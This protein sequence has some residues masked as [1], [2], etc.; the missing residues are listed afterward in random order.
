MSWK[1]I[2]IHKKDLNLRLTLLGGQSFR[3][4]QLTNSSNEEIFIGVKIVLFI[5]V[6]KKNP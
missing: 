1:R 2:A 4:K 6:N 5:P 3:W